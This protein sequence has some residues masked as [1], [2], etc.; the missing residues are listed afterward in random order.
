MQQREF[1]IIWRCKSDSNFTLWHYFLPCFC[2]FL[3]DEYKTVYVKNKIHMHCFLK[4]SVSVENH[5]T[6]FAPFLWSCMAYMST[7]ERKPLWSGFQPGEGKRT[8]KR[9]LQYLDR[10]RAQESLLIVHVQLSESFKYSPPSLLTRCFKQLGLFSISVRKWWPCLT[11]VQGKLLQASTGVGFSSTAAALALWA[12][13]RSMWTPQNRV[14]INRYF[15]C[16]YYYHYHHHHQL[17]GWTTK[18]MGNGNGTI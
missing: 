12:F 10:G 6:I 4:Y 13:T 1:S 2:K 15:H 18:G 7:V 3:K 14:F 11:E 5:E 9:Q 8:C 16:C 17:L